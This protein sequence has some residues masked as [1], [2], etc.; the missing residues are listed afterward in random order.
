[1]L[2]KHVFNQIEEPITEV[3]VQIKYSPTTKS[4]LTE[5]EVLSE[6]VTVFLD[7][8]S[9]GRDDRLEV[10]FADKFVKQF[11]ELAPKAVITY[12]PLHFLL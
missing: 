2:A 3:L 7:Y 12:D 6:G 10:K 11:S 8:V 9:I 1:M 5:V 4:Y